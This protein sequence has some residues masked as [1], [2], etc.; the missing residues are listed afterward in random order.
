[1]KSA[2]LESKETFD[3]TS[4]TP[5]QLIEVTHDVEIFSN[6]VKQSS[7]MTFMN[8]TKKT[9]E[10]ELV[11]PLP[12]SATICGFALEVKDVMCEASIVEKEKAKISFEKDVKS[13]SQGDA[14]VELV[15]GNTYKTKI[16][17]LLPNAPKKIRLD[18]IC[19]LEQDNSF[20]IPIEFKKHENLK[21]SIVNVSI[22]NSDQEPNI[23]SIDVKPDRT[24]DDF[25]F[26]LTEVELKD[27]DILKIKTFPKQST[28]CLIEDNGENLFF[29]IK[30]FIQYEKIENEEKS[31][32]NVGILID[33]SFSSKNSVELQSKF[34]RNYME[35]QDKNL[36]IEI[37]PFSNILFE[38]K[39]FSCKDIQE[40]ETLIKSIPRDGSTNLTRSISK[41]M[42]NTSNDFDYLMLFSD[43]LENV[44]DNFNL[45][46]KSSSPIYSFNFEK[47]SNMKYLE[48]I[49]Q[50]TNSQAFDLSNFDKDDFSKIIETIGNGQFSFLNAEFDSNDITEFYPSCSKNF[51]GDYFHCNG[52][53][54]KDT[55]ITLNY[56]VGNKVLKSTT[57]ELKSKNARKSK[58]LSILW[59]KS[60]ID[61][62]SVFSE[63]NKDQLLE[64]G[65]KYSLVTP[66]TSLL[67]LESLD[68]FLKHKIVPPKSRK[69]LHD[70]YIARIEKDEKTEISNSKSKLEKVEVMWKK[71]LAWW[72]KWDQKKEK[73]TISSNQNNVKNENEKVV[74]VSK[75]TKEKVDEL[76]KAET[77]MMEAKI[78]KEIEEEKKK[79]AELRRIK[80]EEKK[81]KERI[82]KRKEEKRLALEEKREQKKIL[83][84]EKKKLKEQ[85]KMENTELS[86]ETIETSEDE[87][88]SSFTNFDKN[89]QISDEFPPLVIVTGTSTVMAGFG[90]D[91]APRAV[92]P[93]VIG[94]PK[95]RSIMVGMGDKDCYIGDEAVSK[96]GILSMKGGGSGGN[97]PT[98]INKPSPSSNRSHQNSNGNSLVIKP[99]NPETPYLTYMKQFDNENLYSQ[100][101]FQ[102]RYYSDSPAFYL[103]CANFFLQ[104][105]LKNYASRILSNIVE[106]D[107]ENHQLLRIVGYKLDEMKELN[108]SE[109]IFRKVLK[110]RPFEPQ[111]YRDLALVLEKLGKFD[112]AIKLFYKTIIGNWNHNYDE[113][114]LTALIELNRLISMNDIKKLPIDLPEIFLKSTPL[115]LRIVM[116]WDTD[117]TDIDLHTIDPFGVEVSYSNKESGRGGLNSRDFTQ[118]YGPEWYMNR[119]ADEGIYAISAKYFSSQQQSLTGGTTILLSIFT[120]YGV[121]GKEN[122]QQIT[123]RLQKASQE[124]VVGYAEVKK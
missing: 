98:S 19:N 76:M 41:I 79:E 1:M 4:F 74:E 66:N 22:M 44:N 61:E 115:D 90:G 54:L 101:I 30:D 69:Q 26:K 8:M 119:N 16:Y 11:F 29:N 5:L 75:L 35:K 82:E 118:G 13:H 14:L 40:V 17:P 105:G 84:E 94:R 2:K 7:T 70:D 86:R 47:S 28:E 55:K 46:F 103:D 120:D 80:E 31:I 32:K 67:V 102:R 59:A 25:S 81:E 58:I 38:S 117:S 104:R 12:E 78:Q 91:D 99:W 49:S 122:S 71:H 109:I 63:E 39:K 108:A 15:A 87:F 20:N 100:Y 124:L 106:L 85:S 92:F 6:Y 114:E 34:I 64:I 96:R 112:E 113:I 88:Q 24:S 121:K 23:P 18:F 50:I 123:V 72:N 62:L 48:Y 43:G 110:L 56:G 68:Q 52:M 51:I 36:K 65:R 3:D 45:K 83:L 93:N 73:I 42:N 89:N 33:T 111:S 97:V 9:L 95:Q 10:G 60:C 37:I 21:K 57:L 27:I 107:L 116:A 77:E 53:L